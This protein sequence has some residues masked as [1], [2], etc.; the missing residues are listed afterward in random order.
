VQTDR[1]VDYYRFISAADSLLQVC[2]IPGTLHPDL[3]NG[4][5]DLAEIVGTQFN[6][7]RSGILL[8]PMQLGGSGDGNDPGLLSPQPSR[9]KRM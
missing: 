2:R 3:G 7:S 4:A 6:V 1:C 5:V 8:Q 9:V